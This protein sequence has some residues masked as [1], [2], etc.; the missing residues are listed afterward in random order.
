MVSKWHHKRYFQIRKMDSS[1]ITFVDTDDA[2]ARI[3][4]A[5]AWN[6][7][8]PT[9]T[10]ALADSDKTLVMTIKHSSLDNQTGWKTAI[11]NLFSDD[12]STWPWAGDDSTDTVEHVKTEWLHE[13]GSVSS[14]STF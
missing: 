11:D 10:Y 14:T 12:R 6:T 1:L 3:A 9:L 8:S 4:F 5:S 7:N 13:D 2:V